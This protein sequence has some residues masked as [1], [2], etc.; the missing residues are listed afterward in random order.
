[1][2]DLAMNGRLSVNEISYRIVCLLSCERWM[3]IWQTQ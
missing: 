3:V 2:N 1:M